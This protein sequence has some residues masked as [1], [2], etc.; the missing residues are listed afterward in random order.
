MAKVPYAYVV[1]GLMYAMIATRSHIAFVLGVVSKYMAN[2]GKKHWKAVSDTRR[3]TF[4]YVFT[5][6]RGTVSWM[7]C[8]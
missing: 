5:F 6:A 7:S 1:G 3:S 4:D 2:L 8:T